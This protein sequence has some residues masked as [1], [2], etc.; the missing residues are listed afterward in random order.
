MPSCWKLVTTSYTR[1]PVPTDTSGYNTKVSYYRKNAV[2]IC[3]GTV[4]IC[5][6]TVLVDSLRT[7][8]EVSLG[9]RGIGYSLLLQVVY[10]MLSDGCVLQHIPVTFV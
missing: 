8:T 9:N 1:Y 4:L 7:S 10:P 2:L 3:H 5:H 6:D